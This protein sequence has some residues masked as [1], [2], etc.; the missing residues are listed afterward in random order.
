MGLATPSYLH[1]CLFCIFKLRYWIYI[2]SLIPKPRSRIPESRFQ[3]S[4]RPT[5]TLHSS[6]K[7]CKSCRKPNRTSSKSW[8]STNASLQNGEDRPHPGSFQIINRSGDGKDH[9]IESWWCKESDKAEVEKTRHCEKMESAVNFPYSVLSTSY[10]R[11]FFWGIYLNAETKS[12]HVSSTHLHLCKT[13][14]GSITHSTTYTTDAIPFSTFKLAIFLY[15]KLT[16]QCPAA[17]L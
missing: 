10:V 8:E 14:E 16:V 3:I 5:D 11:R 9:A 17:P 1:N 12:L 2:W 13:Q 15:C 7:S 6:G 4:R